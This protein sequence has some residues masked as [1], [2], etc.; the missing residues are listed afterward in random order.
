VTVGGIYYLR[1]QKIPFRL[2]PD[3]AKLAGLMKIG[4]P[5][6]ITEAGY[7]LLRR[8]DIWVIAI[9]AGPTAVGY[10][11]LSLLIMDFA[12]VLSQK[13]VAQ[14]LSPH[15]LT[16]FGR[17]KSHADI[18][19]FYEVPARLFCYVLPPIVGAGT[20][21]IAIFTHALLPQFN[22]GIGAAQVT[23]WTMLFVALHFSINSY[24]AA[25]NLIPKI[26]KAMVTMIVIAFAAQATVLKLG[27]GIEG[28]AWCMLATS[29][30]WA[31]VELYVARTSCGESTVTALAFIASLYL[32]L[33]VSIALRAVA[34]AL[35][36]DVW[37]P[38]IHGTVLEPIARMMF[39]L[40]F[41]LPVLI[42]YELRFSMLR[43]VRR[44]M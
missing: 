39:F 29:A 42:G 25:A 10:Y 2:W 21:L 4:V 38:G 30:A 5:F 22:A 33:V 15:M 1:K 7:D 34:Q 8:V 31:G 36:I 17:T 43:T 27:F 9:M 16:K 12:T 20:F 11:G 13:G 6:S 3:R 23:L 18:A 41:Y 32:P 44:A 40:L 37:V 28:A 26:I 35:P 24:F 14:V 19:M